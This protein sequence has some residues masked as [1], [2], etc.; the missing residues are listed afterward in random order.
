MIVCPSCGNRI[1]WFANRESINGIVFHRRCARTVDRALVPPV[2]PATKSGKPMSLLRVSAVVCAIVGFYNLFSALAWIVIG[3]AQNGLSML[4][5]L[6]ELLIL[7]HWHPIRPMTQTQGCRKSM[8]GKPPTSL[9][10]SMTFDISVARS[11]A[12]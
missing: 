12:V 3:F 6:P 8:R 9:L 1:S 7:V 2:P 10:G 5:V 11:L 4:A